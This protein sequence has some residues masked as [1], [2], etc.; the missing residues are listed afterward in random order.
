MFTT[1]ALVSAL[2]MTVFYLALSLY[3]L[4]AAALATVSLY[5]GALL[6]KFLRHKPILAAALLTAGLLSIRT[7]IMFLTG[8]PSATSCNPWRARS[9]SRPRSRRQRSPAAPSSTGWPT[10]SARSP[11]NCPHICA[12]TGSSADC[13]RSGR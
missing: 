4:R 3:G 7:V 13:P 1:L 8:A 9:R 2:P 11:R 12:S 10:S 5:Y 6:L